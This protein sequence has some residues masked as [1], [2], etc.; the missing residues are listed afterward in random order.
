M[1][2]RPAYWDSSRERSVMLAL[3]AGRGCSDICSVAYHI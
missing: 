3:D 2:E 1:P